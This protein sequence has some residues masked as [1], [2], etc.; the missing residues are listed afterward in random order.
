MG[1][2]ANRWLPVSTQIAAQNVNKQ[3]TFNN[4]RHGIHDDESYG[5]LMND[6]KTV[7]HEWKMVQLREIMECKD[8]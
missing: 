7:R 2:L 4:F 5:I 6:F 1:L 3:L 8:C